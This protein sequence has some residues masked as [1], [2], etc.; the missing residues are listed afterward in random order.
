MHI[1]GLTTKQ[2]ELISSFIPKECEV[3]LFGSRVKGGYRENSDLDICIL[4]DVPRSTVT[5]INECFEESDLPFTVD[6]VLYKD[7]TDDFKKII[8]V[9]GVKLIRN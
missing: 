5:R 6:V 8:D 3:K 7:C 9:T 4:S 2:L 1:P